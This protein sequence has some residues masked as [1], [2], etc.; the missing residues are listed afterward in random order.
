MNFKRA[1]A[2]ITTN[3]LLFIEPSMHELL[4]LSNTLL[5][6]TSQHSPL[7]IDTFTEDLLDNLNKD[8]LTKCMDFKVDISDD[9]C[10]KLARIIDN[11][12]S[13]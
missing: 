4:A 7:C 8:L 1:I 10:I 3:Q 13:K 11:V 2:G 12:D 6:C 5:L 9:A